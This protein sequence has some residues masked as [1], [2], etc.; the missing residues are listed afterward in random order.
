MIPDMALATLH[1]LSNEDQDAVA[2]VCIA[3]LE[4]VGADNPEVPLFLER[5]RDDA[6]FWSSCAHQVELEAYMV[7]SVD[8]LAG[9]SLTHKQIK[10]LAA[11][12]FNRM[13]ADTKTKFK[14]WIN[15]YDE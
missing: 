5:V 11:M 13:D 9:S 2:A 8:A 15:Q 1:A 7:A 14:E 6:R 12:S 3:Y 10:R 4:G